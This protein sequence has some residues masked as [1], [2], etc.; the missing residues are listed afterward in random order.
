ML[1]WRSGPCACVLCRVCVCAYRA[2]A[3]ACS[4][5]R[6]T[7]VGQKAV[8]KALNEGLNSDTASAAHGRPEAECSECALYVMLGAGDDPL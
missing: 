4:R 5:R 1:G 2:C 7:H 3:R 6:D 8:Q